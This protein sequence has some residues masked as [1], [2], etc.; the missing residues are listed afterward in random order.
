MPGEGRFQ[1]IGAI[2]RHED[3]VLIE[4]G[5]QAG[6]TGVTSR[7]F[8]RPQAVGGRADGVHHLIV[9]AVEIALELEEFRAA[10]ERPRQPQTVHGRLGARAGQTDSFAA[11]NRLAQ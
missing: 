4:T 3:H 1:K 7:R 10:G 6:G 2:I 9:I 8:L 5:G 11:R